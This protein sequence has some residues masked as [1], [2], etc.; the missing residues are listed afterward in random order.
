MNR[1]TTNKDNDKKSIGKLTTSEEEKVYFC[2][3]QE[4]L[5]EKLITNDADGLRKMNIKQL[6]LNIF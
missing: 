1:P 4:I 3:N 6:D 5:Y 2:L